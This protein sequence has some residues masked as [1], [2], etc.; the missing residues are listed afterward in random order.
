VNASVLQGKSVEIMP[1]NS[2][3]DA[4]S[5]QAQ[6]FQALGKQLGLNVTIYNDS[7]VPTQ[8]MAGIEAATAARDQ[9][10]VGLCGIVP[11]LVSSQLQAAHAAGLSFIDGNYNETNYYTGLD[12]ETAVNT[13]QGI[14]DDVDEAI[15]N[16]NGKAMHALVVTSPSIIQGPAG[17]AAA[18]TAVQAACPKVCSVVNLSIPIQNW[19]TSTQSEVQQELVSHPDINAVIIVFDGIVQ[20]AYNAV[21]SMHRP[22]LEIYTWGGSRTVEAY[23]LEHG[24]LIAADPGPDEQW[25]AWEAMDQTIRLL[26]GKP[27]ASVNNEVAPNRFWTPDNVAEF[28]GPAGTYGNRGFDD[29]A[30]INGF[31]TLWGVPPS[32]SAFSAFTTGTS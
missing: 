20:F 9:A 24:S 17:A 31:F 25:D 21:A 32:S 1:V 7:G 22:G 14:T 27:A 26:S 18:Q 2:Q 5:T 15:L 4:C 19:A 13:T 10:I 12:G 16:Q 3:I 28:F 29:G 30:F 23:M 6:D 11:Q 8:W